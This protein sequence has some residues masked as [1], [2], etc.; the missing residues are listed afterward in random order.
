[1]S[2]VR[3][4]E[5]LPLST[6]INKVLRIC[7]TNERRGGSVATDLFQY[8][9]LLKNEIRN[10]FWAVRRRDDTATAVLR[11]QT[12]LTKVEST[13]GDVDQLIDQP[14]AASL[15]YAQLVSLV[16][17]ARAEL[18][19]FHLDNHESLNPQRGCTEAHP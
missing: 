1:M 10:F 18:K 9:N 2:P 17:T 4:T 7:E 8:V 13:I 16:Y 6:R 12:A 14:L 11:L 5:P 19:H 3:N 15:G